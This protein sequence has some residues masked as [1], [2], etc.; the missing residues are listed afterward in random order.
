MV[1]PLDCLD[2][3]CFVSNTVD[4]TLIPP[5]EIWR[6][7]SDTNE[8]QEV[9]IVVI[10]SIIKQGFVHTEFPNDWREDDAVDSIYKYAIVDS[11]YKDAI[12]CDS[13]KLTGK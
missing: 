4:V 3:Q 7:F 5:G 1:Y 11:I 12:P 8:T 2:T 13:F 10:N 9:F 6:I